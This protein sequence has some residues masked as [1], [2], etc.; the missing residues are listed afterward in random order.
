MQG[1]ANEKI[2]QRAA[3]QICTLTRSRQAHVGL[4]LASAAAED[5]TIVVALL[6]EEK[7]ILT[8]LKGAL[9]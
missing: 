3:E 5:G 1:N 9:P 6:P 4:D 2:G 8:A 7:Y